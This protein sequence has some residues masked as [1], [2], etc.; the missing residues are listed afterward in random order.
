M[1]L[2]IYAFSL[3]LAG[4]ANVGYSYDIS[5]RDRTRLVLAEVPGQESVSDRFGFE[6]E[7]GHGRVPIQDPP[8]N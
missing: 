6:D 1:S 8:P 3:R 2:Y 5:K 7:I 4:F